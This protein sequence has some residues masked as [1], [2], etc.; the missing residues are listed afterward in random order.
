ME[1]GYPFLST[2]SFDSISTEK[3]KKLKLN[4]NSGRPSLNLVKAERNWEPLQ[5]VSFL[6]ATIM[7]KKRETSDSYT[8]NDFS[9]GSSTV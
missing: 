5:F 7:A 8:S 2:P 4:G 6:V 9:E 3:L 1:G